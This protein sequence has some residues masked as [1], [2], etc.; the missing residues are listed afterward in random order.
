MDL[1]Q[2]PPRL[3]AI[4]ELVPADT[5]LVDV[6]TDHGLLPIRLLHDGRIASAIASD[7]RPG[8]L[9]HAKNSALINQTENIRFVL[10][11][12]LEGIPPD[13][14]DTI[15]IAGMGGENIA[16]I[17]SS[18]PWS[19]EKLLIMQTMSRPDILRRFLCSSGL[20]IND[21]RLVMDNRRIYSVIA[22]QK[23]IPLDLSDAEYY[24]GPY[25]L[26]SRQPLF[27]AYIDRW[28][29]RIH[30]AL[31]GLALSHGTD[32]NVRV[33]H[34]RHVYEQMAEMCMKKQK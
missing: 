11:N 23:G 9:S 28:M 14:T 32:R 3:A 20:R 18:S 15:V 17:L 12:G 7:I 5:R 25:E 27:P 31:D 1:G 2:L 30:N 13:E 4:A 24:L 21:E 8:P 6:G 34:L 10:C 19:R 22:A 29:K 26:I 33:F 16:S